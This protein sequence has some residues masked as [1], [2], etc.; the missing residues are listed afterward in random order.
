MDEGDELVGVAKVGDMAN[1]R[2]RPEGGVRQMVGQ[3]AGNTVEE[4]GAS[5]P[6]RQEDR[7]EKLGQLGTV[8][9]GRIGVVQFL[10]P[11]VH[12]P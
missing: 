12:E 11:P 2:Q 1:S 4:R 3:E 7:D 9:P 10:G 5:L 6:G 8:G